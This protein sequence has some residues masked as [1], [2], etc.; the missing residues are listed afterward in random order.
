[1]DKRI[2]ELSRTDTLNSVDLLVVAT[3]PTGEPLT[4]SIRFSDFQSALTGKEN[5]GVASSLVSGHEL[6]YDHS[7]IVTALQSES[8][9]V[10][11]TSEAALFV[12]G[13]ASKLA[14]IEE[15]AEVNVQSDWNQTINTA[16]DYIKN[17]PTIPTQYTDALAVSAIKSDED[18]SA[19]NWNTAYGWGNHASA[20]YVTGTPWTA[21][22]Y[23]TNISD[24]DLSTADNSVSKFITIGDVPA[25]TDP[26][27]LNWYNNGSPNLISL[28]IG[29]PAEDPSSGRIYAGSTIGVLLDSG[30]AQG[31]FRSGSDSAGGCPTFNFYRSRN[32][33]L[34]PKGLS[35]DDRIFDITGYSPDANGRFRSSGVFMLVSDGGSLASSSPGKWIWQLNGLNKFIITRNSITLGS[36]STDTITHTGRMIV[37]TLSSDPTITST[38]GTIGEIAYF[39]NKFYG[40]VAT[41][42]SDT[43]WVALN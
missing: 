32:T 14:G 22:G 21:E 16:D 1:M 38:A 9:P 2:T 40:K 17:K 8:D 29:S 26:V 15:G 19:T 25:E 39:N 24:Q 37:R 41:T 35:A 7:L 27:F 28:K 11:S 42:A 36:A 3:D 10:Y 12:A 20:G 30:Q 43:N 31:T 33:Y 23:L 18:W 34:S 5:A 6:T 4:K 13:D